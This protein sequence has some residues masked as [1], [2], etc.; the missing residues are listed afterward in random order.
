MPLTIF[1]VLFLTVM[2]TDSDEKGAI[3]FSLL[4]L[5]AYIILVL[6][7]IVLVSLKQFLWNKYQLRQKILNNWEKYKIVLIIAGIL[8]ILLFRGPLIAIL[9]IWFIDWVSERMKNWKAFWVWFFALTPFL[10]LFIYILLIVGM[11]G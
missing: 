11:V 9:S 8:L 3:T 6:I 5:A 1:L 7:Y 4:L 2:S 10:L